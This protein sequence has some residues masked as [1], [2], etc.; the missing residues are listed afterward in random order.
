LL[1]LN[2][3]A[4][5][6]GEATALDG[7]SLTVARGEIYGL[8]G[9]NGSGKSTALN[10]V[11]GLLDPDSGRVEWTNQ[12]TAPGA[13]S[14]IGVCAQQ[15]ALYRDL[16][17]AEHLD[18]HARIQGLRA[19]HRAARVAEVM[20]LFGL[21]AY[22]G[23]TA[24]Q[25]SGGWQQRLHLAC[26]VVHGPELLVLDEPTSAVDLEARHDL[27]ALI[28]TLQAQGMSI[29]LTTHH[30]DEA[31]RLCSRIGILQRGRLAAEGTL[32]ELCARVPAQ[33]VAL[34]RG[35]DDNALRKRAHALGW[36]TRTYAGQLACLLPAAAT[37]Q[38]VVKAFDGLAVRSATLQPIGLQ[39]AYL[40]VLQPV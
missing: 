29:L 37:L 28:E 32:G 21:A 39:H 30:L 8:L 11:C 12:I 5:R 35:E 13:A 40:E 36:M 23:R 19:P 10:I 27:W 33:A 7:L 31:E 2:A 18:F 26:A 1:R 20:A 15:P 9:P 4:K 6:F 34:L 3:L 25:L 22:A 14:R 17:P 24:A 38:D 16:R